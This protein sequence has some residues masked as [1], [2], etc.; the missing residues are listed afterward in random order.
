MKLLKNLLLIAIF[1]LAQQ[2]FSSDT[3]GAASRSSAA[4]A[5][6]DEIRILTLMREAR[7]QRAILRSENI[8]TTTIA[9]LLGKLKNIADSEMITPQMSKQA[10]VYLGNLNLAFQ[11]YR[12]KCKPKCPSR[13]MA[14]RL[15]SSIENKIK[16]RMN[17]K[18]QF[19]IR[20]SQQEPNS[21]NLRLFEGAENVAKTLYA[22]ISTSN[23]PS[24]ELNTRIIKEIY[25][26]IQQKLKAY[27]Q[28]QKQVAIDALVKISQQGK[29]Q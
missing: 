15:K 17:Q 22:F 7:Q 25:K 24:K 3:S 20:L 6:P 16:A 2:A 21:S 11:S 13:E 5:D 14:R 1:T 10:L 23:K 29:K 9:P 28:Q 8:Y 12:C 27:Q 19:L 18:F 4:N 26:S